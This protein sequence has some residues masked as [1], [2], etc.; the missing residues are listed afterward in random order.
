MLTFGYSHCPDH[1]KRALGALQRVAEPTRGDD[2]SG[3]PLQVLFVTVDSRKDT[4]TVLA[5]FLGDFDSSFLGLRGED[6]ATAQLAQ[7]LGVIFLREYPDEQGNYLVQH[8][9]I[10]LLVDPEAR[11]IAGF[12]LPYDSEHMLERLSTVVARERSRAP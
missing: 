9:N 4:P 11:L 12:G 8:T 3:K 2:W 5:R 1:C 10:I 7:Q 6:R